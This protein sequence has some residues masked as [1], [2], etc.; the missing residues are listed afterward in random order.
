MQLQAYAPIGIDLYSGC[1]ATCGMLAAGVRPYIAASHHEKDLELA[2]AQAA[3]CKDNFRQIKTLQ[4]SW[5]ELRASKFAELP[6]KPEIL[7]I[8]ISTARS[9]DVVQTYLG[10]KEVIEIVGAE[11]IT[12][13]GAPLGML[14]KNGSYPEPFKGVVE[15]LEKCDYLHYTER[16][17]YQ[18]WI[19]QDKEKGFLMAWRRNRKPL[20]LP[21]YSMLLS[22]QDALTP[23]IKLT[24]LEPL[25]AQQ[26][27]I[28]EYTKY[29]AV[30]ALLV[31]RIGIDK[32]P[33]IRQG[34][35]PSFHLTNS[36]WRDSKGTAHPYAVNIWLKSKFV[37][38]DM[39]FIARL[40][41]FPDWW[42]LHPDVGVNGATFSSALP[43]KFY[44]EF[45]KVNF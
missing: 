29:H 34:A 37:Y 4:K 25:K 3:M 10:I 5:K 1:G 40:C 27:A 14:S 17:N 41:G 7:H 45:L 15:V 16:I 32:A 6:K 22:W 24:N 39:R 20:Q 11:C 21:G 8:S 13:E 12:I 23:D 9:A 2:G 30:E 35:E 38:P 33:Q 26:L 19:P 43:P 44:A 36:I 31:Q 42:E 28:D 18:Y